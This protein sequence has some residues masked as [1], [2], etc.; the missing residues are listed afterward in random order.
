MRRATNSMMT[1]STVLAV[2]LLMMVMVLPLTAT[3]ADEFA[4]TG[5]LKGTVF[6]QHY[7]DGVPQAYILVESE[8]G[9]T[10]ARTTDE[11]GEYRFNLPYGPYSLKVFIGEEEVANAS[12][13]QVDSS[14]LVHDVLLAFTID[15]PVA[16]HGVIKVEGTKVSKSKVVFEGIGNSYRNETVT[17]GNGRYSLDVPYGMLRVAVYDGADHVGHKDIGPFVDAGDN[18]VKMDI[19][20]TGEAPSFDDW[21]DFFVATWTAVAIWAAI[22]FGLVVGYFYLNRRVDQWLA[23][24]RHRFSLPVSEMM[25]YAMKGYMRVIFLY[26]SLQAMELFL[27]F[28]LEAA[29]WIRFWL[30]AFVTVL[31]LWV[32]ARLL[33]QLIDYIMIRLRQQKMAAGSEVP[34]TAYIFIHGILRYLVIAIFGFFILLIILSGAGLYDEIAGGFT[35][36]VDVN[37]GYLVLLVLLVILFFITNR[38]VKLTLGQMKETSTRF[39]PQMIGIFGLLAK[40]AIAGLFSVLFIFTLLTMAGMQEMGALIMALLTTTVGMIIAMTTT[41][42]IGNAL[43]GMVLMSLKPIEKG[44]WVAIAD[45]DFGYVI[46]VSTFFTRL[47]TFR[48]EVVEIPNNLVLA[49]EIKNYS[50]NDNIGIEVELGIGYDVPADHVLDLLKNGAKGTSGIL[51]DPKPQAMVTDFGDYSIQY[52]LRAFTCQVDRYFQTKLSL[53]QNLQEL[54]YT[55]GIEIMT[56][57]QLINREDASPTRDEVIKRYADHLKHKEVHEAKD[58]KVA[59]G[60]EMLNGNNEKTS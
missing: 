17:D 31:I 41:G 25:A 26:A 60:M 38:F 53:M 42:A 57:W 47:R 51:R 5:V 19:M 7:E 6:N 48:N 34:E 33:M 2:W 32:T 28:D 59:A 30:W 44:Q 11:K 12:V 40:I 37:L 35:G 29:V 50:K 18:E 23:E 22:V 52:L 1:R 45:N 49:Q 39:T 8:V 10:E 36:F 21:T 58:E 24:D 56:P 15:E 4:D 3:A 54:F 9:Y 13:I 14:P 46:E 55:E 27:D 43:S 16:L 20:R